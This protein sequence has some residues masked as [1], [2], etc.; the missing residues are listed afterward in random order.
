MGGDKDT[1]KRGDNAC[2]MG[3][4]LRVFLDHSGF[5][6]EHQG[7][8]EAIVVAGETAKPSTAYNRELEGGARQAGESYKLAGE[9]DSDSGNA[10][11]SLEL[12]KL[13]ASLVYSCGEK[14]AFECQA[15]FA[16]TIQQDNCGTYKAGWYSCQPCYLGNGFEGFVNPFIWNKETK[17]LQLKFKQENIECFV[18]YGVALSY[19]ANKGT[20]SDGFGDSDTPGICD[21]GV[22]YNLEGPCPARFA[23]VCQQNNIG[24]ADATNGKTN[25]AAWGL[26][27]L[28]SATTAANEALAVHN[29]Q[30]QYTNAI[31]AS[32]ESEVQGIDVNGHLTC[33]NLENNDDTSDQSRLLKWSVG[34]VSKCRPIKC[35]PGSGLGAQAFGINLGTPTYLSQDQIN[36]NATDNVLSDDTPLMCEASCLFNFC[37]FNVPVF[38]DYTNKFDYAAG[39]KE[40]SHKTASAIICGMRPSRISGIECSG[41]STKCFNKHILDC[42]VE[43]G[44]DE[45]EE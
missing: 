31:T 10:G 9:I 3:C 13:M 8:V 34:C 19:A 32:C 20:I 45:D 15:G 37:G 35:L 7:K 1:L 25:Y 28:G 26:A 44:L 39:A 18:H 43:G 6:D 27:A 30:K 42:R 4:D 29:G 24:K 22:C 21:L 23:L 40:G 11:E 33:A 41:E 14:S 38:V 17:G 16:K 36:N 5:C 2:L 12:A